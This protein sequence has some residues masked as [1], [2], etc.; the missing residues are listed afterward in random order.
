[1]SHINSCM[2]PHLNPLSLVNANPSLDSCIPERPTR[3]NDYATTVNSDYTTAVTLDKSA[4]LRVSFTNPFG[5]LFGAERAN[6]TDFPASTAS[7]IPLNRTAQFYI[8]VYF[9]VG[10]QV[11]IDGVLR[12]RIDR[13]GQASV[14]MCAPLPVH[15]SAETTSFVKR[16]GFVEGM[17][18][19]KYPGVLVRRV[20]YKVRYFG[21]YPKLALGSSW[22][23]PCEKV[24]G[25]QEEEVL[26]LVV[27]MGDEEEED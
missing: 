25:E 9:I 20:N 19:G 13:S 22:R 1:M 10:L 16:E 5:A 6:T 21:G 23:Y 26:E 3:E 17:I 15:V 2:Q 24:R 12:Q 11:I 18:W 8:R 7:D 27:S 4:K 14:N